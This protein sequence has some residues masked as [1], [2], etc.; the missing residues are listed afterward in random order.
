MS[1]PTEGQIPDAAPA[2]PAAPAPAKTDDA[3]PD[4]ARQKITSANNEAA[5]F[6]VQLREEQAARKVLE[7]Q[8]VTL[9]AAS[10][11]SSTALSSV[12]SDFDKLVTAIQ[13]EVPHQH[14]FAFA[15]TLQ[16]ANETELAAHAAELKTMFGA[17][18]GPA[19][20]VDRFQ[21]HGGGAPANDPATQ[22]AEML[23][24]QLTR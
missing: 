7:E 12:Q 10:S 21:G 5:S 18:S 6:R 19:A 22:F 2:A 13:A 11:T 15:K 9:N 3:L 17:T 8:V 24:S 16:G 1:E 4:W 14:V 20:A 23:Q